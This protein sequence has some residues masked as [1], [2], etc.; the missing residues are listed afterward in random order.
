VIF[1]FFLLNF[2][3]LTKLFGVSRLIF[4][5]QNVY[6]KFFNYENFKKVFKQK[7]LRKI[8]IDDF[9]TFNP[10]IVCFEELYF[11]PVGNYH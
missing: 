9:N 8:Q 5:L 3:P 7:S 11:I 4:G 1:R 6:V 2:G 10:K